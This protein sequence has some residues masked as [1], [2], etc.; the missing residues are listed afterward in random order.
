MVRI[1]T[2]M[3][4]AQMSRV[5]PSRRP[6]TSREVERDRVHAGALTVVIDHAIPRPV[7]AE[8]MHD[9]LDSALFQA[10]LNGFLNPGDEYV[11]LGTAG[12]RVSVDVQSP[13]VAMAKSLLM[14]ASRAFWGFARELGLLG[15]VGSVVTAAAHSLRQIGT[16]AV[17]QFARSGHRG[18][19]L[20]SVGGI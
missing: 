15:L 13:V 1:D 10:P 20:G 18:A 12:Q 11:H 7:R 4:P 9:A 3:I 17:G 19:P 6:T 5:H 14:N 2:P 8:R 16:V